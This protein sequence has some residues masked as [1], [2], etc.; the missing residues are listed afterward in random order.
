MAEDAC[1]VPPSVAVYVSLTVSRSF[2]SAAKTCITQL[3]AYIIVVASVL[4]AV[5]VT[6][7][8]MGHPL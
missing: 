7:H 6:E 8:E 4:V 1:D 2:G 5:S 3:T